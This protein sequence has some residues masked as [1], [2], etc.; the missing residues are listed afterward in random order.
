MY[1]F[2]GNACIPGTIFVIVEAWMA[3]HGILLIFS[4]MLYN[5][6]KKRFR[7]KSLGEGA[8]SLIDAQKI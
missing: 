8:T 2:L 5:R 4:F 1:D 6:A 7:Q 3:L